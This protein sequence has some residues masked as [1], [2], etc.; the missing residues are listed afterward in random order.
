M[1]V[2]YPRCCGLDI[3][4]KTVVAC[5][6]TAEAG[7]QPV[8]VIR[9]FRTMTV[10]LLALADWLHTAACTHVAMESTGVY[11]RPIDNLLEG[12]C[13][14][15]V[16]NAQHIK[17]VPGRKT[18]VKD[19]EWIAELLRHGLLRGS[20]IPAKAQRQLRELTRYRTTLVQDRAR[21]INR[22]Q[23]V[24]EDANIKLAAVVTDIRGV[25][26]RAMLEALIAGPRDVDALAEL[27]RGR[28]RAKRD[29]LAEALQG[30]F[31]SHH[32]FLVTE[33]LSQI[34]DFDE[35]IDRVSAL[36]GQHL[37]AEQEAI[38][39]LDTIPGVS[40]RTA[41]I[42]LA[43]SGTDM[44]RFPSA[45]HLASWAGMCPGH[46]ESAGKHLSGKTRKGSRWLRQV[47][48][49]AAHVAAKT[50]QTYLAAQYQRIAARRGKKRAL[51]ALG[52][53]ILPIVYYLLTR[54]QPY[55]DLGTAYFD[56]LEQH[57]VQQRLVHRL[58]RLGYQVSL[59]P[60]V[61]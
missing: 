4:K 47:L 52:H 45:K 23:A 1:E 44:T 27:A 10:D 55:Q 9:T 57:R 48:V 21:V 35:A 28:L 24:L 2:L 14:L 11:W 12:L 3:H 5:L 25:S 42:L 29:Q 40:Q 56:K 20:F 19:A 17:A 18:D 33:Y 58:E 43:E 30:Y 61:A 53:T 34:D 39:L 37:E 26:A 54:K 60:S 8:K 36:L 6:I 32:S 50:K 46:H 51:M 22:L 7:Q 15:L 41:E 16:V 13:E 31:T 49:E 38:A 59:Q